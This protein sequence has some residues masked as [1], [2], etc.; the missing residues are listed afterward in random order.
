[1]D[2][3][4]YTISRR[5]QA[6]SKL[7]E[8]PE[9]IESIIS[10]NDICSFQELANDLGGLDELKRLSENCRFNKKLN[11]FILKHHNKLS[12]ISHDDNHLC[13]DHNLADLLESGGGV[14]SMAYKAGGIWDLANMCDGFEALVNTVGGL[15]N[16]FNS[17]PGGLAEVAAGM[18]GFS[19]LI[20]KAPG[21]LKSIIDAVP[22]G[23]NDVIS[24][25]GGL[26][27]LTAEI[28]TDSLKDYL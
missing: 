17:F 18:G 1:M 4:I 28:G 10:K 3:Y 25:A 7:F 6:V 14:S 20:S 9:Y 26:D 27:A 23:I 5:T 21:G 2:K 16:L 19:V 15:D 22:G 11:K 13:D 8:E 24:A 12:E